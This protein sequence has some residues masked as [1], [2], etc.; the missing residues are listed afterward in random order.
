MKFL[1]KAALITAVI[2]AP[3]LAR[4]NGPYEQTSRDKTMVIHSTRTVS[5]VSSTHVVLIDLS[6]I[7]NYPHKER[8]EIH[9][10]GYEITVDKLAASTGTLKIG[11]VDAINFASGTVT[12]FDRLPFEKS[13]SNNVVTLKANFEEALINTHAN[14]HTPGG[15]VIGT[16]PFIL[17]NDRTQ[18]SALFQT[19]VNLPSTTG[20]TFPGLGDI[21]LYLSNGD[22]TNTI[23]VITKIMYHTHERK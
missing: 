8:G 20:S 12:F 17:S 15:N 22:A 1:K 6:D 4:A 23:D 5:V 16:T 18:Q 3:L 11:V 13:V 21:I 2:F 9:I 7:V 19:D 10:I 14:G